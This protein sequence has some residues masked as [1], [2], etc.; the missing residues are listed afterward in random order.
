MLLV[1]LCAFVCDSDLPKQNFLR[2]KPARFVLPYEGGV[3]SCK[4]SFRG[5]TPK[6]NA[7]EENE[8]KTNATRFE[9]K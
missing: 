3:V 5:E 4:S 9:G 2:N 7:A 6:N 1:C 8:N